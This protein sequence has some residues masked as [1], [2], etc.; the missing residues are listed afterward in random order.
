MSEND[1]R[2]TIFEGILK[3]SNFPP[4]ALSAIQETFHEARVASMEPG[5][6]YEDSSGA[7]QEK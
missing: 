3:A 5:Q 7:I 4:R 1:N 6:K 2:W